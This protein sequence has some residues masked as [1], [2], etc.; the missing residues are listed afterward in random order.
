MRVLI[1]LGFISLLL[2]GCATALPVAG[3]RARDVGDMTV[4][5][6]VFYLCAQ[7]FS[8]IKRNEPKFP[9][10]GQGVELICGKIE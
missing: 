10:L 4:E 1:A 5:T 9:N 7:P 2:S 6:A 3:D 8:A